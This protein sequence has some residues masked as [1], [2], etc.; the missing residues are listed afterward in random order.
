MNVFFGPVRN[1]PSWSW[2]G[3]DTVKELSKYI[4]I[5]TYRNEHVPPKS[6]VIVVIKQLPSKKYFDLADSFKSKIIYCPID[7]FLSEKHLRGCGELLKRCSLVLSHSERLLEYLRDYCKAQYIDHHGKFFLEQPSSYKEEG[8][9]LW[10]GGLQ[11]TPYLINWLNRFPIKAPIKL[12]TDLSNERAEAAGNSICK[13]FDFKLSIQ[14][15]K[16]NGYEAEEWSESIQTK[17]LKEAKAAIDIKGTD[18]NQAHK[19][20]TKAQKYVCSGLPLAMNEGESVEYFRNRG[21]YITSPR[22]QAEWFS[23]EYWEKTQEIGTILKPKLAVEAIA[24]E[25]LKHINGILHGS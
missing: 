25:F 23:R 5:H 20:P 1:Y 9:V 13:R 6:K 19:P 2:V 15:G 7:Y 24:Q 11:Y 17:A 8:Y 3:E 16:L 4:D 18:F 22:N 14:N 12:L 10:V 21:F